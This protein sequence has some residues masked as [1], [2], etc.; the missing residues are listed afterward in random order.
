MSTEIEDS[1][2]VA[3]CRACDW[4]AAGLRAFEDA[5]DHT[6]ATGHHTTASGVSV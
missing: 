6:Y 1:S 5:L 4:L 3:E 2:T